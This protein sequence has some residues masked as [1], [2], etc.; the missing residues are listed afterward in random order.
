MSSLGFRNSCRRLCVSKE[1][2]LSQIGYKAF[3]S[4]VGIHF[5]EAQRLFRLTPTKE[6][7][8]RTYYHPGYSGQS[9]Y[10]E[11]VKDYARDLHRK[12]SEALQEYARESQSL[13]QSFPE[14]LL[15][16]SA[17][18]SFEV[19]ALKDRMQQLERKRDQLKRIGLVAEDRTYPF[20]VAALE[21]VTD[22]QRSV[23]T[24]YVDDTARK[25]GVFDGIAQRIEIMLDIINK[26]FQHKTI[27]IGREKGLAAVTPEGKVLN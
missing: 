3:R 1:C 10:V 14:R 22:A 9:L 2:L 15:G 24:L 6:A 25:L 26:K 13:D 18:S 17:W 27:Q 20:D 12:I 4:R 16:A 23:M 5:I 21:K 19:Q 7:E 11:T 8:Y